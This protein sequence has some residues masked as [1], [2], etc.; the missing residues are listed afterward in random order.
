M[1]RFNRLAGLTLL[2]GALM[3]PLL[4]AP[5][6]HAAEMLPCNLSRPYRD[7]NGD[8]FEDAVVGDPY[9]TVDGHAEA[10]TITVLFGADDQRIGEGRRQTMTQ[11]DF[12]ETPEAGDH[13][14][15][16][17]AL[18][19]TSTDGC[20]GILVGSPGED[21]DGLNSA[22]MAHVYTI[23]P[24]SEGPQPE[25]SVVNLDQSDL[26]GTV[27]AG[28]E[29]GYSVAAL[30]GNDEYEVKFAFAA[31]G[32]NND[33]GV[34]NTTMSLGLG[35]GTQHRQGSGGVPGQFR[36]GDRFGEAIGF[37]WY[38]PTNE[39]EEWFLY[40]GA[41]GDLINGHAS[42]GS[43]TV[44]TYHATARVFT[45]DSPGIPGTAETGDRFGA[46]LTQ[47]ELPPFPD[48]RMVAIGAPGEDVGS[49]KDAGS[50]TVLKRS[51]T[52]FLPTIS[53]TQAT[54][55]IAGTVEAGDQ[56]G[57]A[58]AYR[59][60]RTLAIGIPGEDLG[61]V[62]DAGSVQIVRVGKSNISTPYP[63]ITEDTPGTPGVVQA[64]SRFGSSVAGLPADD[65][66]PRN[67]PSSYGESAFAISSPF[68]AGGSV[69]VLS[70]NAANNRSWQPG[71]GGTGVRFGQSVA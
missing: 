56:F 10:G 11:A 46:S 36:A 19:R 47:S 60:D 18:N 9:A 2:C 61:S 41:P 14:G 35:G 44:V 7:L 24:A 48:P 59:D 71:A 45:Q 30:G 31:P 64:N 1:V 69:F 70:N 8:G 37:Y 49:V 65:S 27:E 25:P 13:F 23:N 39:A 28:D 57:A 54:A 53:L 58:L 4:G 68:Q 15:W 62:A 29:L 40:V 67:P 55:G 16:A 52:T 26:G 42:A 21:I 34:V 43:V 22:G 63:S 33:A 20:Y 17:L 3:V 5:T 6:A 12:G 66:I 51:G 32:E 50:V 38:L